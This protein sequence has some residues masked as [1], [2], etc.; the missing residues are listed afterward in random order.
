MS[1]AFCSYYKMKAGQFII[2]LYKWMNGYISGF[3]KGGV[4]CRCG[5]KAGNI[6]E[7]EDILD[8]AKW[9]NK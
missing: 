4:Q 6:R 7:S 3:C 5:W 2:F 9:A 8:F 1:T